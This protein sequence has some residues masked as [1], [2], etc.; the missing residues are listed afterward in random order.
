MSRA[1]KKHI[2]KKGKIRKRE[3]SIKM[4]VERKGRRGRD[5]TH[6]FSLAILVF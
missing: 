3:I 6:D 5:Q 1:E 4:W 2:S